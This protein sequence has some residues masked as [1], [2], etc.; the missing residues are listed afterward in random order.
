MS[1]RSS[2]PAALFAALGDTTRLGLISKLAV[3]GPQSISRLSEGTTVTR[4]AITK[5]LRVLEETGLVHVAQQ[6]R[7]RV[8]QLEYARFK[9]AQRFLDAVSQRWDAAL[10]RLRMQVEGE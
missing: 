5:H 4:Q 6:G 9:E 1:V 8:C 3:G 7:E 2:E 10:E